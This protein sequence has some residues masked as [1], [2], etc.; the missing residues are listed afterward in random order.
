[1]TIVVKEPVPI[2]E[3][4]CFECNSIIRY[5]KSET[6]YQFLNCPVCGMPNSASTYKPVCYQAETE[7]SE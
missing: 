5:K 6:S 7:E 4:R 2:Y 1:M 3:L